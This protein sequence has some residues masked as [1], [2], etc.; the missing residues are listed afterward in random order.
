MFENFGL[1]LYMIHDLLVR[2]LV[3]VDLVSSH[4]E[5]RLRHY[6][7]VSLDCNCFINVLQ[8]GRVGPAHLLVVHL[9]R[10]HGLRGQVTKGRHKVT[11][12]LVVALLKV[13]LGD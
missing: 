11:L 2:H 3:V 9:D 12:K 1:R 4:S 13:V 8:Y 6:L 5:R 10:V 7:N